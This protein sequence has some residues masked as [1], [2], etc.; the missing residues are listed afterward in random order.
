MKKNLILIT[1]LFFSQF[2][3]GQE[4][5]YQLIID[6]QPY[7]ELENDTSLNAGEVWDDPEYLI[8]IGFDFEFFGNTFNEAII[9][10]G[11]VAIGA[12]FEPPFGIIG[13]AQDFIDRGY[14]GESISPISY[15]VEGTPG[16]RILKVQWKNA[17]FYNTVSSG[18]DNDSINHQIWLYESDQSFEFRFG[19]N[20]VLDGGVSFDS[21][22]GLSPTIVFDE[23]SADEI[24]DHVA[25][26]EGDPS[27]PTI[28]SVADILE[29][30]FDRFITN[31]RFTGEPELGQV[32]RFVKNT[33]PVNSIKL[34]SN[35]F[36]VTPNPVRNQFQILNKSS[37]EIDKISFYSLNGQSVKLPNGNFNQNTNLVNIEHLP[38]GIYFIKIQTSEGIWNQ[39]LVK[40]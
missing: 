14:N 8:P 22:N 31:I 16:N 34:P 5:P 36:Q 37:Y 40:Q 25:L 15:L 24:I 33:S 18:I 1:T 12:I 39:K 19:N 11:L 7:T 38:N 3:F 20:F 30:D 17:G 21:G 10:D 32:Y 26:L 29:D 28:N 27:S 13:I 2:S 4:F 6:Q 35:T 9:A 23:S